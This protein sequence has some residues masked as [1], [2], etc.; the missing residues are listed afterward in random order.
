M[1]DKPPSPPL[2]S[3]N[4]TKEIA[5]ADKLSL[6]AGIIGC[7]D[8]CDA[9]G[10]TGWLASK[11]AVNQ[12]L[13]VDVF[14]DGQPIARAMADQFRADLAKAG[15]GDGSSGF[16]IVPPA[17]L[18][19][20]DEHTIEVR[21]AASGVELSGS[22]KTFQA[23]LAGRSGI[24][25][26]GR[27][28]IGWARLPDNVDAPVPLEIVED[29]SVI[30]TGMGAPDSAVSNI[31]HFRLP[32]PESTI[33]GRLHR[34]SIRG[35]HPP[36]VL[37]E[38]EAV[39]P[40]GPDQA[41]AS[42]HHESGRL[43]AAPLR[44]DPGHA[45]E[46]T[47]VMGEIGGISRG[48]VF[49]WFV[50]T[51]GA[52][53]ARLEV[54]LDEIA[55]GTLQPSVMRVDIVGAASVGYRCGFK[56]DLKNKIDTFTGQGLVIRDTASGAL[57]P[58]GPLRLDRNLA[59]GALDGVKGMEAS[60]WAISAAPESGAAPVEILIDGE[61]AGRVLA[62]AKRPDR[63]RKGV[64][65]PECGFSFQVP[66]RWHDGHRHTVTARVQGCDRP[67]PG[68]AEFK[69]RVENQID[70]FQ[71]HRVSG[72]IV[73]VEMPAC[74]VA[75]DLWINGECVRKNVVP[76]TARQDVEKLVLGA[77]AIGLPL[78]FDVLLAR[79]AKWNA[80]LNYM[81][82][83][84][85]GTR[86]PLAR[87]RFVAVSRIGL[88]EH[89]EQFAA[90]L[91][92]DSAGGVTASPSSARDFVLR[93]EF[94][95]EVISELRKDPFDQPILVK[96]PSVP[97]A[98]NVAA[99]D[100]P[101]DVI[102]PVYKGYQETLDCIR[103]VLATRGEVAMEVVVINDCGPDTR[104]NAALRKL[105][106][107][108][109][110]TLIEN[111]KNRGFV[112]T[113]NIGMRLHGDRDVL[114]LNSDTVVPKGWLATLRRA[115]Y[116]A[117]NIGTV[118]PLSNRATIF[119]LPRT[120]FD[121]D[122]PLG[123][124]VDEVSALCAEHNRGVIVDVP[125]AVGFCMYI[126]RQALIEV[127]PFNEERWARGYGEEND[128]CVSAAALGWRNVAACDVFVQHHGA[129]SFDTEK[130]P[131]IQ[132]N[133]AKLNVLYPDYPLRIQR[134]LESDP[135]AAPRGRVNAALF[136]RLGT[137][138]ILFVTHGL[139]GGTETA[140]RGLVQAHAREGRKALI[141]RSTPSGKLMLAPA[142]APH[143]ETLVTEYPRDSSAETLAEHL[144]GLAVE[145]VYFHHTLGFHFD[146]WRL[147]ELLGVPY[148][149]M[150]HDFYL[151]CPRINLIDESGVFCGQPDLAA[152]ERCVR[153]APM[154]HDAGARLEE[155][156][157]TV[158]QW[159]QLHADRL[160][161]ARRVVTP[162]ENAR[163]HFRKSLPADGVEVLPHPEPPFDFKRRRWNGALPHSVAV[164]GAIGPHKGASLLLDCARYALRENLPLR[165]VIIGYTD[166]DPS[167]AELENVQIT[168][169]YKPDDLVE[170]VEASGCTTA[171]FLSVWPETYSYTLSEAWRMGLHPVAFD[172]GAPAE[173][174][175][176][177]GNGTLMPLTRNPDEIVATL[178]RV[179]DTPEPARP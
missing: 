167:F 30:G 13:E 121:N 146:I 110:F 153:G 160:R 49:G 5:P 155:A 9:N 73:N 88:L 8:K 34:F 26:G 2:H 45:G 149:V 165:F 103:S 7:F 104:L 38:L 36:V 125:T 175:R 105:A 120:C 10:I 107:V 157:G 158:A 56:F 134:F 162:S 17:L 138:F 51:T 174:I 31:V 176:E 25:L 84:L 81:E 116:A 151:A 61:L 100:A 12:R 117:P 53:E 118:T 16:K 109:G 40:G 80:E 113:V 111:E 6:T 123:L 154:N 67:L 142:T 75:F 161:G 48:V 1:T 35:T 24:R 136:K 85:P 177:T 58:P 89:L 63:A 127:G 148:E 164:L 83:C 93:T 139:G 76:N 147:P 82:Q 106:A 41:S 27:A 15:I 87:Q 79:P 102:I 145:Y 101:I 44:A 115:A 99:A 52:G 46:S 168:G 28:L 112:A 74:P 152:C 42:R 150:I 4:Q 19:D 97:V 54:L 60:G 166:R 130:A 90:R 92:A 18:F 11:V 129:V 86:E 66:A 78:G 132:E 141:L 178:R 3:D 126:R 128:F 119:S 77:T 156:G 171:L 143:E 172:I 69:C 144:R 22:P 47:S 91:C 70:I 96:S 133:L 37:G 39:T 140:I 71:A 21:E 55:V 95:P 137:G 94:L 14:A 169:P 131:R 43:R 65:H 124:S 179:L 135:L 50:G 170:I 163:A 57:L 59:W 68:S 62:N 64:P 173:R 159:R 33:D 20:G 114:L 108:E 29:G 122:M 23:T 32:L 72:W 98:R